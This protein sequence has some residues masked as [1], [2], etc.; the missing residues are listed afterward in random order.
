[1]ASILIFQK[2][3]LDIIIFQKFS[4]KEDSIDHSMTIWKIRMKDDRYR[5]IIN[6][7]DFNIPKLI[8]VKIVL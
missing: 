6:G 5:R 7:F 2:V 4:W 8:G 3:S 1:M